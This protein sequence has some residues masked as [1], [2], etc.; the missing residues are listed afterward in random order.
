[1]KFKIGDKV[2]LNKNKKEFKYRRGPVSYNEIGTIE[3]VDKDEYVVN[4]PSHSCWYGKED[5][6]ELATFTKSDLKDG[7]KC[8]LKNGK[9]V[10]YGSSS[11][12]EST[13]CFENLTD[14]F[15]FEPNDEVSIVKVERPIKYE[16]VF[17]RKEEILDNTE[18]N[19]L[20]GVI[21]PFRD[22]VKFIKKQQEIGDDEDKSFIEISVDD[23]TPIMLPYFDTDTM[24]KGMEDN[25]EYSLEEL[26]L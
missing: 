19:Y 25:K 15:K 6:L 4:F 3:T 17:E 14:D 20:R 16:T 12:Y 26:G 1:M 24:Y 7:D 11:K 8:T 23:D 9:V 2:R 5:E 13:Y 22:R 10:F 21:R 18:K